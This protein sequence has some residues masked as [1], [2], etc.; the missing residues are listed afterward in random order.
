MARQQ[1]YL[2]LD[3][4]ASPGLSE[5]DA[6]TA[7]YDPAACREGKLWETDTLTCMSCKVV[8]VPNPARV[9]ERSSCRYCFHYICDFCALAA[10]K[11]DHKC[12]CHQREALFSDVG[13]RRF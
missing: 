1:G 4:R 3:H 11:A 12:G 10:T 5:A 7:G 9:R 2:F 8:V 6:R 13:R